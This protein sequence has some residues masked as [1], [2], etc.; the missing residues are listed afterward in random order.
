MKAYIPTHYR[1]KQ[2]DLEAE[3]ELTSEPEA[4]AFFNTVKSN[5]LNINRW[6]DIAMLPAA[7]FVLTDS[8][9]REKEKAVA[10]EG[11]LVRID[12]PGPGTAAGD[13]YDWVQ[14][15]KIQEEIGEGVE[16]CALTLRPTKSPS[17]QDEGVAHFFEEAATSTLIVKRESKRVVAFYHGRNEVVNTE[18]ERPLDNLR[19]RV[20]GWTAKMGLSYPQWESLIQGL[21]KKKQ[22]AP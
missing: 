10:E 6:Y 20:V 14:V 19:N 5:L 7:T 18:M 1:G 15:E 8:R 12:V 9:G 13:G 22:I 2:V 4:K 11:D 3:V 21:V 17:A 16:L